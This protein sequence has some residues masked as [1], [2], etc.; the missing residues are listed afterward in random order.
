M[1]LVDV[2]LALVFGLLAAFIAGQIT[3]RGS[4]LYEATLERLVRLGR[5]RAQGLD[6]DTGEETFTVTKAM[7]QQALEEHTKPAK[8]AWASNFLWFS[9]GA[10]VSLFTSEIRGLVGLG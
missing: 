6:A 7:I 8:F 2:V 3:G 5:M 9:A 10:L 4:K 1:S